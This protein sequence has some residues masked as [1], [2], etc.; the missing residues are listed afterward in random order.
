M[1]VL[2]LFKRRFETYLIN[3][4]RIFIA[5]LT[6][7]CIFRKRFLSFPI[8]NYIFIDVMIFFL[9]FFKSIDCNLRL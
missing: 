1:E 4:G 9:H 3:L 7:L 2:D 8:I 5:C 6:E